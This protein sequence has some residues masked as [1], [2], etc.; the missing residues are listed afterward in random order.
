MRRFL[1]LYQDR[2]MMPE[3]FLR[4][5]DRAG[6]A[7]ERPRWQ[8]VPTWSLPQDLWVLQ[9]LIEETR[10]EL[11]VETGTRY[12][13]T[14]LFFAGLFDLIGAG[15]VVSVDVE[16]WPAA[17]RVRE[18]P[19]IELLEGSSTSPEIVARV[20]ELAAGKRVMVNLDSEHSAEHVLAELD[21]YAPL[22]SSGCYLVV[23]D[24]VLGRGFPPLGG[25]RGPGHALEQWLP[26][27]PE[28]EVDAGRERLGTFSPGGFLRRR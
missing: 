16:Q 19:R 5:G 11:L 6:G 9:E 17:P 15:S 14:A 7:D 24:T 2:I 18:H 13:G 27:H 28:F 21:A 26:S 3:H 10:P 23:D 4:D 25:W 20:R 1:R 12:G 22:V 8:G